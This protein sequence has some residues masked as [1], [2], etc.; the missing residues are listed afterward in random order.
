MYTGQDRRPGLAATYSRAYIVEGGIQVAL[1]R[2]PACAQRAQREQGIYRRMVGHPT[3]H[4]EPRTTNY[5]IA[6]R[7]S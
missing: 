7:K 3:S 4:R 6:L 2:S 5:S 1:R